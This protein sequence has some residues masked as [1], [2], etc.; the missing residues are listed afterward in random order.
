MSNSILDHLRST[1]TPTAVSELS[2]ALGEAPGPTQKALD[3]LLPAVTAG[4]IN[5]TTGQQGATQLYQ[6]LRDTPFAQDPTLSQ[7]VNV[8]D[9]RQKA[10][11][12]GNGL[13]KQLYPDQPN[14]LAEATAQYSGVSLGSAGT[15]SGLVMS[16]LMGFLH[17]QFT[18]RSLMQAQLTALLLGETDSARLA[19]PTGFAALLG[20]LLGAPR[21]VSTIPLRT[22]TIPPASRDDHPAGTVWW[23]WLLGALA[24]LALLFLLLRGYKGDKTQPMSESSSSVASD[25]VASDLDGNGPEVRVAIDLPGGRKLSVV[26][27]SFTDSL[28]RYLAATG[29]QAPRVFNFDNLTFETD[30]ARITAQARSHVDDL[31]Q[32]MQAYPNLQIRIE[33]NTDSTG[34]EAI[35]DPLSGERADMVKQALIQGGIAAGRVRTR[36]RGDTKPVASNQTAA[37]RQKNRRIDVVITKL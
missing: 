31:I 4:V 6:L 24:L 26:E 33:G 32:I 10:A 19:I 37:G 11:E 15:L 9:H 3:G 1:F 34:G 12:S 29:R 2:R 8:G 16:V 25:T 18:S 28:A 7:L 27:H 20:W 21:P 17:Q 14:R 35:N 5:R 23:R 36:E 22:E 13:F 30:S